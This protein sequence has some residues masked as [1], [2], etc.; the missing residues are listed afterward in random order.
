M[1]KIEQQIPALIR[2]LADRE[3][4][5]EAYIYTSWLPEQ[6]PV[7]VPREQSLIR[8]AP[9]KVQPQSTLEEAHEAMLEAM[10]TEPERDPEEAETIPNNEDRPNES[11]Q[12]TP[13]TVDENIKLIAEEEELVIEEKK[14]VLAPV[15]IPVV[16]G[17]LTSYERL[18]RLIGLTE[19]ADIFVGSGDASV[20]RRALAAH[21]GSEPRDVRVDRLLRLMLRL[22]PQGDQED[23]ERSKMI[24]AIGDILPKYNQWVRMRLEARHMGASGTFFED[25]SRLG[26]ALHRVPG[27]GVRVPLNADTY[28]LPEPSN[29][30]ELRQQTER[31]IQ[32]MHLPAAGGIS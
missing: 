25:A 27:P 9:L 21:V 10:E 32:S 30:N 14:T 28:P 4:E 29:V 3:I 17:D 7:L 20:V 22:L 5:D 12:T 26:T 18:L 1:V 16:K 31:L 8:K 6:R 11:T 15:S 19:E 13:L 23:A 2:H 24:D